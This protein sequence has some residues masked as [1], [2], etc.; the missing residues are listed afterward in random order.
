MSNGCYLLT[1]YY[2]GD[3]LERMEQEIYWNF[4]SALKHMEDSWGLEDER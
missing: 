4:D 3:P 2:T 1:I